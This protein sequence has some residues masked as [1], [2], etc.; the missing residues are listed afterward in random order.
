MNKLKQAARKINWKIANLAF[1]AELLITY[2]MPLAR[3][4]ASGQAGF[5]FPFL[6]V[7]EKHLSVN[8]FSSVQV[9]I[10]A[11]LGDVI[12]LYFLFLGCRALYRG[13]RRSLKKG[14]LS[15][16]KNLMSTQKES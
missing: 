8:L 14:N 13:L 12:A 5:P 7:Y 15:K 1:W 3:E 6:T 2:L 4:D 10:G 16:Q 11:L 9:S